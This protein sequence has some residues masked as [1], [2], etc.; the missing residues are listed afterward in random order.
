MSI[1]KY[2]PKIK[3]IDEKSPY[4]GQKLKISMR[5]YDHLHTGSSDTLFF[6]DTDSGC[7][8]FLSNQ[9]DM[10]LLESEEIKFETNRLGAN[11]GDI[12]KIIESGSGSFRK[13]FTIKEPHK[14]TRIDSSGDV[15]FDN[16]E[17]VQFRPKVQVIS[18][19]MDEV[20]A[21]T[22]DWPIIVKG[23]H[24]S[25]EQVQVRYSDEKVI[26]V[27]HIWLRFQRLSEEDADELGLDITKTPINGFIIH[28]R[29]RPKGVITKATGVWFE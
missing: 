21:P 6:V 10:K 18:P 14:I 1:S 8:E 27:D 23:G 9:V 22:A 4:F 11:V 15:E 25:L 20:Y 13:D 29:S 7:L 26:D 5:Y 28:E 2:I 19:K 16:G 17:S 24:F 12:V 3:V